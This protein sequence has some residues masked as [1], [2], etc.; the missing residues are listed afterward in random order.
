MATPTLA[1]R[2]LTTSVWENRL[3]RAWHIQTDVNLRASRDAKHSCQ[4]SW[5]TASAAAPMPCYDNFPSFAESIRL[6][7]ACKMDIV[8][9]FK[10][11]YLRQRMLP[12]VVKCCKVVFVEYRN[13]RVTQSGPSKHH[14][15]GWEA[16]GER[17]CDRA[18]LKRGPVVED[19][20]EQAAQSSW[21]RTRVRCECM[22][23]CL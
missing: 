7:K 5:R 20:R 16:R 12:V 10:G 6:R 17:S 18:Y 14:Q 4:A 3:S 9:R 21:H 11:H 8:E 15:D 1:T 19:G 13:A 22:E 2:L 23:I